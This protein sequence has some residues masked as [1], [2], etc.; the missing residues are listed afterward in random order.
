MVSD[1]FYIRDLIWTSTGVMQDI[2]RETVVI[3][4]ADL[5]VAIGSFILDIQLF[6]EQNSPPNSNLFIPP[7]E[8]SASELL[9]G[10]MIHAPVGVHAIPGAMGKSR[11]ISSLGWAVPEVKMP[12]KQ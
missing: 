6:Q 11:P 4:L 2:L 3:F 8:C 7:R 12:V 10:K 1:N 9:D 5:D